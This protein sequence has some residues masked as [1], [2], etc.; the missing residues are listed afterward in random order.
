MRLIQTSLL[1]QKALVFNYMP[2]KLCKNR[3]GWIIEYYVENPLT[4]EMCRVRKRVHFI[5]KRYKSVRDAESHC[6]KIIYDINAKMA[7][8]INPMFSDDNPVGY[9]TIAEVIKK[10]L[11]E[12]TRE[13]RPDTMR[14]YKS[15]SNIFLNYIS[16]T[17]L[18]FI[19]KFGKIEAA[20]YLDYIYNVRKISR[21]SYNN[22]LKF[23]R[24]VF[25]WAI[26]KGYILTNP[27]EQ[28][29]TKKKE[30]KNRT[31][32]DS[33]SRKKLMEYLN[34]NDKQ[35]LIVLKL[36][37]SALIR[38]KEI[39]N[40]RVSDIDFNNKTVCV[41]SKAAKNH[42]TRYIALTDD[43]LND[44]NYINDF[45]K[46]MFL[47]SQNMMPGYTQAHR[48]KYGKMWVK[49]RDN[50]KLPKTMQLYSL[51]DSGITDMLKAGIDPLTVKQ[52]ADHHSLEMTT[53]YSKHADPNLIKIIREK[54]PAF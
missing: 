41:N 4:F 5:K 52:H 32:V 28:M 48:A 51:R 34:A 9:T 12:K 54:A 35:F 46:D 29:K 6:Q 2:A 1:N 17:S 22:Y 39:T 19:C 8:G 26:E 43:I 13:V 49:L 10:F 45:K 30:E 38:P 24:V 31:L 7:N 27:F 14:S 16:K 44:L 36:V 11:E 42:N 53:I 33:A 21:R 20:Q 15:F 40:L 25:N 23:I 37:Y 18:A 47:I 50:L 3:S